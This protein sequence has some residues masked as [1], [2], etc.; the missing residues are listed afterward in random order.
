MQVVQLVLAETLGVL[1]QSLP[2]IQVPAKSYQPEAEDALR[3]GPA[4]VVLV[5]GL[6]PVSGQ[7][8]GHV[9]QEAEDHGG[10]A[11]SQT[12]VGQIGEEYRVEIVSDS[13]T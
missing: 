12:Q 5:P 8:V 3:H 4:D 6:V 7:E 2:V 10:Q 11:A 9:D 13:I 1:L